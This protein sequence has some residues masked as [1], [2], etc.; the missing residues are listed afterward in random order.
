MQKLNYAKGI[1]RILIVYWFLLFY[2]I[3]ALVWWFIALNHQ[4]EVLAGL[5]LQGL[6]ANNISYSAQKQ[7]IEAEQHRRTSQYI[8]EG[9]T[10]LLLTLAGA[11]FVF[12]AVRKELEVSRQQQNFMIAITHELK[13]PIAIANL[14]LETLQKRSLS[15]DQ[16]STLITNTIQ[17][18]T[19]LNDLCNNLLLAGQFEAGGYKI[20]KEETDL[21]ELADSLTSTYIRR[22]PQREIRKEIQEGVYLQGDKMLLQMAINN[23]LDNA[24]KYS[25]KEKAVTLKLSQSN[26]NTMLAVEDEGT[27]IADIEKEKVFY[28]FYRIGNQYTREAKGTGLGL[29]LTKRIAAQHSANVTIRDNIPSGSIFEIHFHSSADKNNG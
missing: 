25:P 28:K 10:F 4:N 12:K 6:D 15:A 26:G 3:A 18:T 27:G 8:G 5:K 19:R 22:F 13:T 17:E 11:G 23:L 7:K 29:F 2:I 24:I 21:S 16:Q 14:N 9:A 1:R 20:I